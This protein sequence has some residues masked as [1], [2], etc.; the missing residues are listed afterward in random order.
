M[1]KIINIML[2]SCFARKFGQIKAQEDG[3]KI[4]K[5]YIIYWGLGIWK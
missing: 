3:N 5:Y 2:K 1:I 4:F